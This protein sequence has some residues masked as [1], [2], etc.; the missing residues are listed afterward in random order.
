MFESLLKLNR[1]LAKSEEPSPFYVGLV[2]ID[3][4]RQKIMLGKRREDG[5][6]TGPGGSAN[7]SEHPKAA[8]IREAF[9]EANLQIKLR[10][11]KE[12][13]SVVVGNGKVC[14]CFLVYVDSKKTKVHSGNDPDKEVHRWEWFGLQDPLP[15]KIDRFRLETIN[16]AKMRVFGLRKSILENPDAGIDLNTAEQSQ[17]E[18]ASRGNQWVETIA[19]LMHGAQYGE[20]PREL[21]LPNHLRLYVSQ[22]D[23]G[24][25][26]AIV[27]KEDPMSG[28]MGEVQTQLMKMTPE[29]MVQALKAKGYLPRDK[30]SST[31]QV[32]E[33]SEYAG[34][35]AALKD[36]EGELHVHLHKSK[37]DQLQELALALVL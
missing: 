26:S 4:D 33:A 21:I 7:V 24:L 14:H 5:M 30:E 34:L 8:A 25:F 29:A 27:K 17:D 36:F 6:W 2:V 22:V 19:S 9:E 13:P 20:T 31:R 32:R 37:A 3:K 15:G 11:L 1:D 12:L 28:D 23:D 35:Y 16:N 18:L 10:D